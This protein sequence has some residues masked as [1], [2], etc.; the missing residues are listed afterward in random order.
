V[1][2]IV[3]LI[4]DEKLLAVE[5]GEA[6]TEKGLR[7]RSVGNKVSH[8]DNLS[9]SSDAHRPTVCPA[10]TIL[11]GR[12]Q[13]AYKMPLRGEAIRTHHATVHTGVIALEPD[14]PRRR[15]ARLR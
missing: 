1:C 14:H 5:H 10:D 12:L 6:S 8:L 4:E 15:W 13:T 3:H 9:L 7:R 2:Q 11:D